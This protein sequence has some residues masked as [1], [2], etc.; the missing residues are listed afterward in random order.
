MKP[1][2]TQ[3]R[4]FSPYILWGWLVYMKCGCLYYFWDKSFLNKVLDKF[5]N[6][7]APFIFEKFCNVDGI[8]AFARK[9]IPAKSVSSEVNTNESTFFKQ[10]FYKTKWLVKCFYNPSRVSSSRQLEMLRKTLD[11][12]FLV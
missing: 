3:F 4:K 10:N 7:T 6:H 12:D 9:E 8:M 2:F 1:Y 5:L 11:L